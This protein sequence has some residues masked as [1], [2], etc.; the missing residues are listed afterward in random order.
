MSDRKKFLIQDKGVSPSDS[1]PLP[2]RKNELA[3]SCGGA[4]GAIAVCLTQN[5]EIRSWN[6]GLS[7]IS[8][9][10]VCGSSVDESKDQR[11]EDGHD[12]SKSEKQSSITE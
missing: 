7:L 4:S 5:S 11:L 6:E 2:F 9:K 8:E 12:D 10:R 3:V 1:L